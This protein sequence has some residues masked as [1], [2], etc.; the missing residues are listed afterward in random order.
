M[1][2]D[3]TP[4]S[5]NNPIFDI[6]QN[7]QSKLSNNDPV[8]PPLKNKQEPH[9]TSSSNSLNDLNLEKISQILNGI[10]MNKDQPMNENNGTNSI[11]S[12]LSNLNIDLNTIMKFQKLF[13]SF[14][15]SD[16]RK[17]LLTS[18]KPFMRQTRQKNV[19]TYITLLSVI[20]AL[21]IFNDKGSE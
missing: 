13:T 17:N 19:D 15:K 18:L 20:S 10:G 3:N 16:P 2:N 4:S 8:S 11:T 14:N 12:N 9:N 6:I 7:L 1:N 21:N 5:E